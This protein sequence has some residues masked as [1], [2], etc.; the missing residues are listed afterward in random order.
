MAAEQMKNIGE[1]MAR[2]LR[3]PDDA[4]LI[5]QTKHRVQE[6]CDAFPLYP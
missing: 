5:E 6:L 1:L 3:R 2:V 4:S